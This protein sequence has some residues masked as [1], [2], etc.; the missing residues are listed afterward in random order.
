MPTV[1]QNIADIAFIAHQPGSTGIMPVIGISVPGCG[2]SASCR[3]LAAE[4]G[5]NYAEFRTSMLDFRDF[6]ALPKLKDGEV[7]YEPIRM[8]GMDLIE[9]GP[10]IVL[11]DEPLSNPAVTVG[12]LEQ[13]A[14]HATHPM[15]LIL[16]V[17]ADRYEE[18]VEIVSRGLSMPKSAIRG[19][20]I[21]DETSLRTEF[22]GYARENGFPE[23]IVAY[24]ESQEDLGGGTPGQWGAIS[25]VERDPAVN[26]RLLGTMRAGLLGDDVA[27][28]YEAWIEENRERFPKA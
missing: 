23:H 14:R 18:L 16:P 27:A 8:V 21:C 19:T 17:A 24:L 28:R 26:R 12:V 7:V 6:Q 3:E 20:T 2:V 1:K 11:I 22:I 5:L 25:N 4:H 13:I 10:C 9:K 15:S